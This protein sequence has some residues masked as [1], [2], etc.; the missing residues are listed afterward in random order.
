VNPIP[1]PA[2]GD[3]PAD[4]TTATVIGWGRLQVSLERKRLCHKTH[5]LACWFG[6]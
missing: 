3:N 2:Q 1:L 4:G 6:A 5:R